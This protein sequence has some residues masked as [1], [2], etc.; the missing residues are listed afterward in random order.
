MIGSDISVTFGFYNIL[1]IKNGMGFE[2]KP[3]GNRVIR[4][5]PMYKMEGCV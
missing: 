3:P 4:K 2:G 1:T 5:V